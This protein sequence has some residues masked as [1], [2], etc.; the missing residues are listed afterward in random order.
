[1]TFFLEPDDLPTTINYD[2]VESP[3]LISISSPEPSK[4]PLSEAALMEQL[5]LPASSSS[6][7]YDVVKLLGYRPVC[8]GNEE[9][10]LP[11][12]SSPAAVKRA[13]QYQENFPLKSMR[14]SPCRLENKVSNQTV[15]PS[16]HEFILQ[17]SPYNHILSTDSF[18]PLNE[19]HIDL[20][21]TSW[22]KKTYMKSA[23]VQ[24]LAGSM[25]V[26]NWEAIVVNCLE[27]YSR[28][29]QLEAHIEKEASYLKNS[30]PNAFSQ[31]T[32]LSIVKLQ[33]DNSTK[34]IIGTDVSN[35]LVTSSIRIDNDSY[36]PELGPT[37]GNLDVTDKTKIYLSKNSIE[38]CNQIIKAKKYNLVMKHELFNLK[39][40]RSKYHLSSTYT[41]SRGFSLFT[42]AMT[43]V[44]VT[45]FTANDCKYITNK[46]A[47]IA[48]NILREVAW[49]VIEG[50]GKLTFKSFKDVTTV[51]PKD[52]NATISKSISSI[53]KL[54]NG[55]DSIQVI[56]NSEL[57]AVLE[58]LSRSIC[59]N[60]ITSANQ[61]IAENV[62][63]IFKL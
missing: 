22:E 21:N 50:G 36:L 12:F 38:K 48:S 28:I 42:H 29:P 52:T 31:Y 27:V 59:N 57:N 51:I 5:N 6:T 40:V 25:V 26:T 53:E 60:G 41:F 18:V 35:F 16:S 1:M 58:I 17:N 30:L 2:R 46:D 3:N 45:V 10:C 43:N 14:I 34:L 24:L 19:S 15:L 8:Y 62:R 56:N 9:I 63:N 44:P 39:Q 37:T 61:K 23:S 47:K 13:L 20:L 55:E 7:A 49:G 4:D 11:F 32:N 54:F 33:N